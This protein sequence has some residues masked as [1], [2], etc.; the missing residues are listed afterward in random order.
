MGK[1]T[2]LLRTEYR[3][4]K[5]KKDFPKSA[6][7]ASTKAKSKYKKENSMERAA[8]GPEIDFYSDV[9]AMDD[10]PG[11][12]KILENKAKEYLRKSRRGKVS[13]KDVDERINGKSEGL[14]SGRKINVGNRSSRKGYHSNGNER[15]YKKS[16]FDFDEDIPF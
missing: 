10:F 8:S 6:Q 5:N 1:I 11:S 16:D 12:E 2:E 9:V 13:K 4:L 15:V 3:K 7:E 14:Y